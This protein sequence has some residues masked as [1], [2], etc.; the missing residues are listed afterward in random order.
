[1]GSGPQGPFDHFFRIKS[2]TCNVEPALIF[3]PDD[4]FLYAVTDSG[5]NRKWGRCMTDVIEAAIRGGASIIQLR[6]RAL[7]LNLSVI[8]IIHTCP[9]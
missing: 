1:M 6:S 3:N 9:F 8:F 5:M 7:S 4:L 2:T